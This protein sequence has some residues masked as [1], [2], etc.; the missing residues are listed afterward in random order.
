MVLGL[1]T[2]P[3]ITMATGENQEARKG[4]CF[5]AGLAVHLLQRLAPACCVWELGP[6][7]VQSGP[8]PIQRVVSRE[9]GAV[10]CGS[11]PS[12]GCA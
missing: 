10:A 7:E 6:A 8:A 2:A 4:G 1:N 9:G 12:L 11:G 5:F 3:S